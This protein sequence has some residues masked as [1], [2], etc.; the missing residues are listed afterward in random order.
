MP[1]SKHIAALAALALKDRVLTPT[2]RQTIVN[3]ALKE[4]MSEEEIN[5]YL[6]AAIKERLKSYSKEDLTRCPICGGLTPLVSDNC[7]YCGSSLQ[8]GSG[9]AAPPPYISSAEADIINQENKNTADEKRNIKVCPNCNAPYPL[10]SNI[11]GYCGHV[12]HEQQDSELNIR[13]L[14]LSIQ[15]SIAR[16]KSVPLPTFVDVMMFRAQILTLFAAIVLLTLSLTFA[17]LAFLEWSA[18]LMVVAVVL[19]FLTKK[20]ASPVAKADDAYYEAL[21]THEMFSRTVDTLYGENPEARQLL[22]SFAGE[23][24]EL[25]KC[26]SVNR[27]KIAAIFIAMILLGCVAP[28][29][30]FS[31][32]K[33]YRDNREEF[34]EIYEISEARK[35]ILPYQDYPVHSSYSQYL[36]CEGDGVVSIDVNS[37]NY[38]FQNS[39][40]LVNPFSCR[41]KVSGIRLV[42]TGKK[43]PDADTSRIAIYLRDK[44]GKILHTGLKWTVL[45]K[46][47]YEEGCS[48]NLFAMLERGKGSYYADFISMEEGSDIHSLKEIADKVEY[49]TIAYYNE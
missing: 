18:L 2:E 36:K 19:L 6:N 28:F 43:L 13:N 10:I 39:F 20:E 5:Q 29:V 35:T 16:L 15:A 45:D 34:A 48:D 24:K 12:L 9:V 37:F 26:R 44:D 40:L 46:V 47:D 4:G 25:E 17:S 38:N 23:I 3:A 32:E 22:S 49:F 21:Y 8:K 11:C 30:D 1:I 33:K 14:I 27:N 31:P 7:L 42:S 41:L